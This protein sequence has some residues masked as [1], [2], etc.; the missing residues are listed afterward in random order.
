MKFENKKIIVTGSTGYIGSCIAKE[1]IN[2]NAIVGCVCRDLNKFYKVFDNLTDRAIPIC[3]DVTD[4]DSLNKGILTFVDKFGD[5]DTLVNCAGGSARKRETK[6]LLQK[7]EVFDEIIS[8]NLMGTI[9]TSHICINNMI[10][11]SIINIS[12]Y[13]GVMGQEYGAEYAAAKGGIITFT[14]SLAKECEINRI[15]V[16][17]VSPGYVPRPEEIAE[18]GYDVC[19]DYSYLPG[20]IEAKDI[21]D[22]VL[23]LA[24]KQAQYITGQN[25]LVDGGSSLSLRRKRE[26]ISEKEYVY[27]DIDIDKKYIIYA[28]GK[29][30]QKYVNYLIENEK[31]NSILCFMD[32]DETK[33]GKSFNGK[34]IIS[35]LEL[36]KQYKDIEIIIATIHFD[37]LNRILKL[38]GV[39]ST[40]VMNYRHLI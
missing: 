19:S 30:S 27:S 3:A 7:K 37:E 2:E 20:K 29:E 39:D 32:S 35:P 24:S 33:W 15:R 8:I 38:L 28:T 25:I 1:F 11:G 26:E 13:I 14:K 17:C 10:K 16:N 23:F 34:K 4:Y 40:R 6:F 22:V 31:Y 18:Y 9:Y 21:A 5:I 36:M 12:S